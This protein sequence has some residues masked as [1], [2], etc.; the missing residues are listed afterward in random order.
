M[1]LIARTISEFREFQSE[2]INAKRVTLGR[3]PV[4]GFVPTMG[5]LH[6]GHY[7]LIRRMR[8]ECDITVVS[9]YVNPTQF[10]PNEDF[11]RYPRTP[12]ADLSGCQAEG[13]DL[14]L[15][16]PDVEMYPEGFQTEVKV[17]KL[18]L[19]FEGLHRPGHFDGVALICCKLFNIVQPNKA[20]FGQKDYQQF[21]V[22]ERMVRDLN[23]PI[24]MIMCPTVREA[25]GLAM[26]S[27]NQYLSKQERAEAASIFK[28]LSAM[29]QAFAAGERNVGR[30]VKLGTAQLS[31]SFRLQ[32]LDIADPLTLLPRKETCQEGDVALI[33]GMLGTTHLI[34][35]IIL[36][37]GL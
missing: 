17:T 31:S 13:V 3:E 8:S 26:S 19:G 15:I 18:S 28:C 11:A 25:D 10:G 27:R 16:P 36:G 23:L 9:I 32:Y 2:F 35:N 14:V 7:S 34:D 33:A 6:G 24:E 4:I 30:L 22:V 12:E 1:M 5:N 21:R 29:K 20:Y 37:G